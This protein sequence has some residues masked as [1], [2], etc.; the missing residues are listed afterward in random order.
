MEYSDMCEAHN[1]F[2]IRSLSVALFP[3]CVQIATVAVL[4]QSR[5]MMLLARGQAPGGEKRLE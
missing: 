1:R 4:R 3:T 5:G 2:M